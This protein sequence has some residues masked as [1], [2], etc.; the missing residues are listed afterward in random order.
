M[1]L[2]L[3]LIGIVGIA[4]MTAL[5]FLHGGSHHGQN[6]GLHAGHHSHGGPVLHHSDA[7]SLHSGMHH[8]QAIAHHGSVHVDTSGPAHSHA[9][10]AHAI[11]NAD[12]A[13][14]VNAA[15]GPHWLLSYIPSPLDIFSICFGAGAVGSLMQARYPQTVATIGAIVGGLVLNYLVIRPLFRIGL[16][17]ESTPTSGLEGLV[18]FTGH[19]ITNFDAS[20]RGL[21]KLTLDGQLVQLLATLEQDEQQKGV[22]VRK[23]DEIVVTQVNARTN[24]CCVTRELSL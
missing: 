8:G 14:L 23:G 2:V 1:F 16:R 17:F 18:A 13:N 19:A 10:T 21:V 9:T 3:L 6:H 5:G 12:R 22:K 20:G 7:G 15:T 4:T 11:A 24:T